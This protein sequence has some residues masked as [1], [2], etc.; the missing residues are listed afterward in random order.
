MAR[1]AIAKY[2]RSGMN[3]PSGPVPVEIRG[4]LRPVPTSPRIN[5]GRIWGGSLM[6]L[7]IFDLF[8]HPPTLEEL[9]GPLAVGS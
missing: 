2:T 4:E 5:A 7:T 8:V 1:E 9:I 3:L 6:L